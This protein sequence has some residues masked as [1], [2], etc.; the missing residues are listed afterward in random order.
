VLER[1]RHLSARRVRRR[2]MSPAV[3]TAIL[4]V[5]GLLWL[6]GAAWML[7]HY[8][9]PQHN[10]FGA[11]PNP[12]EPWLM[13]L[14]GVLAVAGVFLLGWVAAAHVP[15]TWRAALGRVSGLWLSGCAVVLVL[16]GY[17]LYYCTGTL[18]EGAGAVHEWLGLAALFAGL[19]HW[20][21]V[22]AQR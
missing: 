9:F 17:A 21:R 3:R 11:L 6:S 8:A 20:T 14:H 2:P 13:R 4:L 18:H 19:A 22:R 15:P 7:V 1:T 12:S 5:S 16:S 10:E